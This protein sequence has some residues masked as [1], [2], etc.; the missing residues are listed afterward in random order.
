M[1]KEGYKKSSRTSTVA[2]T[3]RSSKWSDSEQILKA[4]YAELTDELDEGCEREESRI[5]INDIT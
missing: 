1:E 4:D 3:S 5:S 2:C